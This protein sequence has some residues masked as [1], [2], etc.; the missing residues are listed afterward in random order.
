MWKLQALINHQKQAVKPEVLNHWDVTKL[1]I[2]SMIGYVMEY[3]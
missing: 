1:D 3:I 2:L